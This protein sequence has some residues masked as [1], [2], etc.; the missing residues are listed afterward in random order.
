[1][2]ISIK[3]L[4]NEGNKLTK[5]ILSKYGFTREVVKDN[6]GDDIKWWSNKDGIYIHEDSWWINEEDGSSYYKEGE[7][8]PEIT[9]SFAVY[10][11]G[12]GSFKGGFSIDTDTQLCN[13]CFSLTN[14][15]LE[16]NHNYEI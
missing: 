14:R 2:E 11:K 9:F 7:Q 3:S 8:A 6:D 1:M 13:L 10:I 15:Q 4:T 16:Y 12:D 5:E